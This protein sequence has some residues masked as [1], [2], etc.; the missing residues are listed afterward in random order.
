MPPLRSEC[1]SST[2]TTAVRATTLPDPGARSR[3][4]ITLTSVRSQ[5]RLSRKRKETR[6][7]IGVRFDYN[8][9]TTM[10]CFDMSRKDKHET[11]PST[12]EHAADRPVVIAIDFSDDSKAALEWGME[13][14][15]LRNAPATI[16]HVVHDPGDAPGYYHTKKKKIMVPLTEAAEQIFDEFIDE[17]RA[18]IPGLKKMD[19]RRVK[20][21]LAKGVPVRRILE[22]S[23]K[24]DARMIVMGSR[25]Q[26]GIKHLLM[27]SKAE[28]VAQLAPIPVMIVKAPA[29]RKNE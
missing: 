9:I 27:G 28:Q 13:E 23:E 15:V 16:L 8:G 22:F 18:E 25:G 14:A 19:D 6:I 3:L 7:W 5:D 26:T 29:R 20:R 1:R 24:C 4:G 2:N 10:D 12:P 11:A 17:C 21:K